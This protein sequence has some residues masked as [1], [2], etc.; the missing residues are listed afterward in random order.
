MLI[1]NSFK[2]FDQVWVMTGGGPGDATMTIITFLYTRLFSDV[3]FAA[4]G[5][6]VLFLLVMIPLSLQF[7]SR[8]KANA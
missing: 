8:R 1:F 2:V 3:G 6:V 7:L 4:A 5:T